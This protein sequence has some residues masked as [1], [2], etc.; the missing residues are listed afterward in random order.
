MGVDTCMRGLPAD[1]S[2]QQA[3][4]APGCYEQE[5]EQLTL[6]PTCAA[7]LTVRSCHVAFAAVYTSFPHVVQGAS[8]TAV[9][10]ESCLTVM[11]VSPRWGRVLCTSWAQS[12]PVL[13][14]TTGLV[15]QSLRLLNF[16]LQ[17]GSHHATSF[18]ST[19]QL[20]PVQQVN[21][22]SATAPTAALVPCP[23]PNHA[24]YRC[25]KPHL[26]QLGLLHAF[27]LL[28]N[29][30]ELLSFHARHLS[31]GQHLYR[32]VHWALAPG[33]GHWGVGSLLTD[34]ELCTG[35]HHLSLDHVSGGAGCHESVL[36]EGP[37]GCAY[38]RGHAARRMVVQ[39]TSTSTY[40]ATA[41]HQQAPWN[42]SASPSDN[43]LAQ[44]PK[45]FKRF[46][47]WHNLHFVQDPRQ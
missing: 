6:L 4:Q 23:Y 5:L 15:L 21:V 42:L 9:S 33:I 37:S 19:R 7:C 39:N 3:L 28:K 29:A 36:A 2:C 8:A 45:A 41:H 38:T 44:A 24:Y 35:T 20:C 43:V 30:L 10:R 11:P 17:A 16:L 47:G 14:I 1:T 34:C 31:L 46:T 12:R 22:R 13:A 25:Q 26:L 32:K 27:V 40:N 18:G